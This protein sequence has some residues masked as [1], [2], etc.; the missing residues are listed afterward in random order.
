[1][2]CTKIGRTHGHNDDLLRNYSVGYKWE[3]EAVSHIS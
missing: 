3:N 2:L 1:M